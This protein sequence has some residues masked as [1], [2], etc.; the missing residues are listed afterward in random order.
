M[1]PRPLQ[2]G[3]KPRKALDRVIRRDGTLECGG[4]PHQ[5]TVLLGARHGGVEHGPLQQGHMDIMQKEHDDR[6]L[7]PLRLMD[8]DGRPQGQ[9]LHFIPDEGHVALRG[10]DVHLEWPGPAPRMTPAS[11]LNTPS[12]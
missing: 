11:P 2:R 10:A 1:W 7:S 3:R 4:R 9:L 8:T 6:K 5:N 12:R